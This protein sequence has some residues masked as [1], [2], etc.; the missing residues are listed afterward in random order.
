MVRMAGSKLLARLLL[1]ICTVT[2]ISLLALTRCG[3][4]NLT[5]DDNI[6]LDDDGMLHFL[7]KKV[8]K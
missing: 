3:F 4:S 1:L 2:L 6:V 5:N 8:N 7:H